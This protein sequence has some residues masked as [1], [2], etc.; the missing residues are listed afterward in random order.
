M[1]TFN[2]FTVSLRHDI[3]LDVTV[4]IFASPDKTAGRFDALRHHIVDKSVLVP[5]LVF[6]KIGLVSPGRFT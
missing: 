5:D 3:G 2:E 4:V 1:L 6:L